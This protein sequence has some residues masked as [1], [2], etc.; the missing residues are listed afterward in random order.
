MVSEVPLANL[1]VISWSSGR[2]T[3]PFRTANCCERI[4][5]SAP[6]SSKKVTGI[7]LRVP[8]NTSCL[9]LLIRDAVLMT[10]ALMVGCCKGASW[11]TKEEVMEEAA[12]MVAGPGFLLLGFVWSSLSFAFV[13]LFFLKAKLFGHS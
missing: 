2:I 11:S 4:L 10:W 3:M 13:E 8:S 7:L 9:G 12:A 6:P 5:W 1:V